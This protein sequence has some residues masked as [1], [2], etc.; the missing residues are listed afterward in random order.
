ML[1]LWILSEPSVPTQT[2]HSEES[3]AEDA[4]AHLAYALATVYKYHRHLLYLVAHLEGGVLHLN[5]EAITLEA[6]LVE[7]NRL[8]HTTAVALEACCGV[9]YIESGDKAHILRGKVAH[10]H[11][12]YRPVYNI[13]TAYI[14]RAYSQI[15]AFVVTRR[16]KARQVVGVV[17]EV[18]I[19]LE[20]V[21]VTIL[22]S[23]LEAGDIG[24]AQAQLART[25]DYEETVVKLGIDKPMHN[26]GCTVRTA[27]VDYEYVEALLKSQHRTDYLLY[28]F[29][30]VVCGDYYYAVA[31]IHNA[32]ISLITLMLTYANTKIQRLF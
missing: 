27:V 19:H 1:C 29:L 7:R 17:R 21:V 28:I 23:P 4:T 10:K 16:I 32:L 3:L 31:G 8:E 18:G 5:L 11:T 26:L 24:G 15:V 25:L 12:A 30:L 20:D 2:H 9:V 6:H 14:T 13:N 22:Q